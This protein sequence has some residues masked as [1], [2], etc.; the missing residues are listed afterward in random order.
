MP[1]PDE[2]KAGFQ[3]LV[4]S[5]MECSSTDRSPNGGVAV[6][7]E[8]E[9][10][11]NTIDS[12]GSNGSNVASS[13]SSTRQQPTSNL[14]AP[15]SLKRR[16]ADSPTASQQQ[17]QQQLAAAD[18]I[19][20]ERANR[21]TI[22]DYI[23]DSKTLNVNVLAGVDGLEDVRNNE[24]NFDS[25]KFSRHHEN[26]RPQETIDNLSNLSDSMQFAT[27]F[28]DKK[29][30]AK[31]F[32][33]AVG[34]AAL[35]SSSSGP[36]DFLLDEDAVDEAPSVSGSSV[37]ST[38]GLGGIKRMRLDSAETEKNVQ[39]ELERQ[40]QHKVITNLIWTNSPYNSKFG[41]AWRDIS[42][43]SHIMNRCDFSRH[44]PPP[45]LRIPPGTSTKPN[46]RAAARRTLTTLR[47]ATRGIAAPPVSGP[48]SA[49]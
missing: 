48:V 25:E 21:V 11:E 34:G 9:D 24:I 16:D 8:A 15:D 36:A 17:Q 31:R 12:T 38:S 22:D 35:S 7:P 49:T 41:L 20:N 43:S 28:G 46:C 18:G 44:P 26:L 23:K 10:D 4:P 29:L 33:S 42:S 32:G 47:S 13:S 3:D 14:V 27:A 39:L 45:P 19:N 1:I 40:H 6:A 30:N 37:A 5:A 2:V